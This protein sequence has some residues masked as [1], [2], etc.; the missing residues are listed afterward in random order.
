M[1]F[2]AFREENCVVRTGIRHIV[3]TVSRRLESLTP[4]P[5][6]IVELDRPIFLVGCAKSGTS[7]LGLLMLAHP[8]LGPTFDCFPQQTFGIQARLNSMLDDGTFGSVARAMEMKDVWDRYFPMQGTSL[9]IGKE[10][11]LLGNPLSEADRGRLI[12][13]LTRTFHQSRFFSKAPFNTFRL[14]ALRELFPDARL[15]AIHRDG[16]EVVASWG[17]KQN[18]WQYFGGYR[19]A[20]ELMARKWNEA[21]D[22]IE[23]YRAELNVKV[24]RYDE[25]TANPQRVLKGLMDFCEVEYLPEVYENVRLSDRSGLWEERIPSEFHGMLQTL[26][27]R[28]CERLAA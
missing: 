11:T 15:I 4:P 13:R 18:R 21:V 23:R 22:H 19:P 14:H 5:S 2:V 17:R 16:R 20:I 24:V 8:E 3:Q 28:N 1:A 27:Q 12:R 26:T 6:K 7:M 25:L 9:R 10:L